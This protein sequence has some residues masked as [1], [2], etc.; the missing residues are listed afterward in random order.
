MNYKVIFTAEFEEQLNRILDY[1]ESLFSKEYAEEYF[2]YLVSQLNNL[3]IF[4][5][6]G[7]KISPLIL[8]AKPTNAFISRKNIVFYRIDEKEKQIFLI[9]IVSS[10]ENYLNLM[11]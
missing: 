10:S 8:D 1:I 6:L 4:P 2:D 7:R 9:T 5:N 11:N 3:E